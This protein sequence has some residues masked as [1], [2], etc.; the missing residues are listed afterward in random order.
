MLVYIGQLWCIVDE[1]LADEGTLKVFVS[2]NHK[3]HVLVKV[4]PKCGYCAQIYKA[5]AADSIEYSV[6][7]LCM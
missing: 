7:V 4:Q 1:T 6:K 2:F 5:Y 3:F